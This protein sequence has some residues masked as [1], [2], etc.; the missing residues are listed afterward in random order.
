MKNSILV[1]SDL[2]SVILVDPTSGGSTL[3]IGKRGVLISVLGTEVC[4]TEVPAELD[5]FIAT[6][7]KRIN[8]FFEFD[9]SDLGKNQ[10]SLTYNDSTNTVFIIGITDIIIEHAEPVEIPQGKVTTM[11]IR[12]KEKPGEGLSSK[13]VILARLEMSGPAIG[14]Q[15]LIRFYHLSAC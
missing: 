4:A 8:P 10:L 5:N 2:K 6:Q 11:A 13:N 9:A 14:G 1:T 7:L 12:L 3:A 15:K